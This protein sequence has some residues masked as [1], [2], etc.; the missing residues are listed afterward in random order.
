M[1]TT[2]T[3]LKISS[4]VCHSINEEC[5]DV[6]EGVSPGTGLKDLRVLTPIFSF[7]FFRALL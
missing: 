7:T 6:Y 2:D 3:S 1:K 5:V 4:V